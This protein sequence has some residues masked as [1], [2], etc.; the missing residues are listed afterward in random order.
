M[1]IIDVHT[2]AFPDAL[3]ERAIAGLA[4]RCGC[5]PHGDGTVAGLVEAMDA[6]G[7]DVSVI[8]SIAT[9]PEHVGSILR[10]CVAA[11]SDR[12]L[13]L[14]SVHPDT[15]DAGGWVRR[16]GE[17]GVGGIKLHTMYQDFRPDDWSRMDAIYSAA[18][19]AA[20][21]ITF[22]A[23]L[24]FGWPAD[25]DRAS[26]VRL[27]RV[28]ERFPQLRMICSHMGGWRMWE[29]S[30]EHLVGRG[31]ELMLETSYSLDQIGP[32]VA[33]RMIRRHGVDRVMFGTDWP[34]ARP[35]DSLRDFGRLGLTDEEKAAVLG[36]TAERVYGI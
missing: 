23:G 33:A 21:V 16:V 29:L 8:C 35:I 17:A 5:R 20:L 3:A 27:A 6:A 26:P 32:D 31:G 14:A 19:E 10:W 12:I 2:H 1:R 25:D 22:H 4:D 28:H 24:D 30:R 9:Q 15:P 36:G 13:P 18:A 7:V 11:R 34:W